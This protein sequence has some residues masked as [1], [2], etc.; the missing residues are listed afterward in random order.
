MA[1]CVA[2]WL[3]GF[4]GQVRGPLVVSCMGARQ[5]NFV[6]VDTPY[7]ISLV[8]GG[9]DLPEFCSREQGAVVSL[10][11]RKGLVLSASREVSFERVAEPNR[12]SKNDIPEDV[13]LAA[14]AWASWSGPLELAFE[15]DLPSGSGLGSSSAFC[16][17]LVQAICALQSRQLADHGL[18]ETAYALERGCLGT[19]VGKQDHY[20]AAFGGVN[21]ITFSPDGAVLVERLPAGTGLLEALE[22][23]FLLF[24]LGSRKCLAEKGLAILV[25]AN[26]RTLREMRDCALSMRHLI[27]SGQ[28]HP[29]DIGELINR[30]WQLKR[31]LNKRISN[32]V[33]DNLISASLSAGAYGAK[34]LGA[35]GGG[36]L[37][38]VADPT[39]HD[40]IRMTLGYPTEL[41]AALGNR[42]SCVL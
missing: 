13:V 29:R 30:N 20:A 28:A 5:V 4:Y 1:R 39:R 2:R 41:T 18:A 38:V 6:S 9:T 25:D 33:V 32:D 37:L 42:G 24:H 23:N 12:G 7:R 36:C 31:D 3:S 16:V 10:T 19:L 14:K 27:C 22:R 34:L 26:L 17:A 11:L 21:Y 15:S 8:G 35:G 40:H